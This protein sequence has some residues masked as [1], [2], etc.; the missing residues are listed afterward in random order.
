MAELRDVAA[1][2][3]AQAQQ[4]LA[5]NERLKDLLEETATWD[6]AAA[7]QA[8][9]QAQAGGSS[10]G[11]ARAGDV[12]AAGALPSGSSAAELEALCGR[13]QRELLLERAKT[14]QLDV[15]VQR[16]DSQLP[17]RGECLGAREGG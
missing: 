7:A 16:V 8:Q 15:Q 12:G 4:G 1:K 2:W 17:G 11:A 10:S 9:A 14:A 6:A 3:E 5:Q 13:L